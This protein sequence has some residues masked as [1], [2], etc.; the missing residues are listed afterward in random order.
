MACTSSVS[1]FL[2][3]E[4]GP[5]SRRPGE[6]HGSRGADKSARS[7]PPSTPQSRDPLL[8]LCPADAYCGV[9]PPPGVATGGRQLWSHGRQHDNLA[10]T[11]WS[12]IA[13]QFSTCGRRCMAWC[14]AAS[15]TCGH[16]LGGV[17]VQQRQSLLYSGRFADVW[18]P[19][20]TLVLPSSRS[21]SGDSWTKSPYPGST[22]T[23][24]TVILTWA[25]AKPPIDV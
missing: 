6:S 7:L 17:S 1:S 20:P 14:S 9:K 5:T 4:V 8:H 2:L 22:P 19:T 3:A 18:T 21:E 25:D 11:C 24:S 10:L 23:F 12:G 13:G 16:L 15:S